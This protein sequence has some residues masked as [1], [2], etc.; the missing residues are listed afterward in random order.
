ME[1]A[2]PYEEPVGREEGAMAPP[3]SRL[4]NDPKQVVFEHICTCACVPCVFTHGL[5]IVVRNA[6][7]PRCGIQFLSADV[8]N[9]KIR[10]AGHISCKPVLSTHSCIEVPG[11]ATNCRITPRMPLFASTSKTFIC[12]EHSRQ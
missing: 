2:Y 1:G 3:S 4:R 8:H 11:D 6:N 7:N 5:V 9:H 12:R 10:T